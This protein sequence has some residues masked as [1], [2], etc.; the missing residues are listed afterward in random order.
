VDDA[1]VIVVGAGL[2]G[3][4]AARELKKAGRSVIVL[5]ARD[6][7]GGRM[8][9]HPIGDG[10]LVEVGGQWVG[11]TQDRLYALA[12]ELGVETFP[13]YNEGQNLLDFG[14]RRSRYTG[15]IPRINPVVLADIGQAQARLDRMAR[16]VP[17]TAP[18]EASKAARWDSQTFE[19]GLRR[20]A[21]TKGGRSLL[22]LAA[23]AVFAVEASDMSLLHALFYM[24]SGGGIDRLVNTAGGAQQDRFVGGSQLLA[25]KMAED[26]GEG[27]RLSQPVRRVE[28]SA[29]GVRVFADGVEVRASRLVVAI[30]PTLAGRIVYDPI[31]PGYRD[32]L[33][34]RVPAGSVIKVNV[35]YD[36]PFW[37]DDGLS[38]QA[39]SDR[40]AVR[41]T[42]D[43]SPPAGSP[44]VLLGFLE[45]E[46]ARRLGRAPQAERR[47]AVIADFVRYFGER[48]RSPIEY[49]EKDWSEEEWTRG[50][51]GA[52]L[53]PGAW[54][55]YGA[56]L[57]Q[58][59]GS[60]HWAGAETATVWS[61]YMDGA[62]QSGQRA[63]EE[64]MA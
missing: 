33:T 63:A 12:K 36:A 52:H 54:T 8:L 2:A 24:H 42:Y 57:R 21:F 58:P 47:G 27:V 29:E 48:A 59:I 7:V 23:G 51:Y 62:L 46:P 13:T 6:R 56:A 19:T 44:G 61:G 11:P 22:R 55:Q 17:L 10:R 1:D 31:L 9:N 64:V 49:V 38:G 40:G 41:V 28:H 18:W 30:P 37:R 16:E 34:Q 35:I 53:A 45:G 14:G 60:I 4:S 39:T 25:I 32:Q 26:L 43:N 15:A 5:E 50:C 20:A 3:L